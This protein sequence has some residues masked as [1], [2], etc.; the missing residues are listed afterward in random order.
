MTDMLINSPAGDAEIGPRVEDPPAAGA[1]AL[2]AELVDTARRCGPVLA[3]NAHD[4][5]VSGGWPTESFEQVRAS[6]LLSIAVPVELGGRGAPIGVVA[7]VQ[8]ELARWC[9]S[10]ALATSMHQHVTSF[11]AWR[12]RR[13]LPGAEAALRRVV[14]EGIV[15]AS[16][17][18]GDTTEPSG[19]ARRVDGGFLVN[20]RKRFVSQSTAMSVLS[21][22]CNY[23]DPA[24]GR[25]VL[26]LSVPVTSAGVVV[27]ET[28][29]A[30]GMRATASNDVEFTDVFVPDERVLADRPHGVLDAPLQVIFSIAFPIISAVY[31]GIADAAEAEARATLGPRTG[32]PLVVRTVGLMRHRLEVAGWALD[33]ALR[34]VGDDPTPSL[35]TVAAVMLA[36]R[37]IAAAAVEVTELAAGLVG[38][39]A[40]RRGHAIERAVRDARA[41]RLHP[42]DP[43]RTL[44]LAGRLAL[45]LDADRPANWT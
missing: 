26:N 5:D 41:A 11:L 21:T 25:R 18:G 7:Q 9:G 17:G 8:R 40:Y 16:T 34:R 37:E 6:G 45:G 29:D 1:A 14:E 43:E 35:A 39:P 38:G 22:M 27:H 12:Y 30:H 10:T 19:W 3:R 36:K 2:A 44:V 13:Q 23:A 4:A 32:D 33:G 42:F 20:G 31:L 15:L 28:W 24:R